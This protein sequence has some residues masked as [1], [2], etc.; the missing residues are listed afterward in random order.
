MENGGSQVTQYQVNLINIRHSQHMIKI[1]QGG[2]G[3]DTFKP[4]SPYETTFAFIHPCFRMFLKRSLNDTPPHHPTSSIF[5]CYPLPIYQPF[6][7]PPPP[8]ENFNYTSSAAPV[9]HTARNMA[10]TWISGPQGS[11][12]CTRLFHRNQWAYPKSTLHH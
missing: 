3:D 11:W 4:P 5:Y 12:S 7:P 8:R 1:L 9:K 6:S 2:R 10:V